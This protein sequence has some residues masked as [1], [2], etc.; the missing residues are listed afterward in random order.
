MLIIASIKR[1]GEL[2]NMFRVEWL[3]YSYSYWDMLRVFFKFSVDTWVM[4]HI[5]HSLLKL[6]RMITGGE[7]NSG[8]LIRC[9]SS[10]I[11]AVALISSIDQTCHCTDNCI[12]RWGRTKIVLHVFLLLV[13]LKFRFSTLVA[14]LRCI[15]SVASSS[16]WFSKVSSNFHYRQ[17]CESL[18][19]TW[20]KILWTVVQ[21]WSLST[22]DP[23]LLVGTVV[24]QV[25]RNNILLIPMENEESKSCSA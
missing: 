9:W 17:S 24:P 16:L 13:L 8:G 25:H 6:W 23:E 7:I 18:D 15:C 11:K 10:T 21:I 4:Q 3:N 22:C 14:L 1:I 19:E 12:W 5:P 2:I 20:L